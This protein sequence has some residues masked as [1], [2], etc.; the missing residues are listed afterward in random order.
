VR[1]AENDIVF[2]QKTMCCFVVPLGCERE[3]DILNPEKQLR[4][5]EMIGTTRVVIVVLG[6]GHQ[7]EN[8]DQIKQEL[9]PGVLSLIPADC[10]NASSI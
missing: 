8:L 7:Y 1:D 3:M 6:R 4:L 10:S 2:A 9:N 5:L